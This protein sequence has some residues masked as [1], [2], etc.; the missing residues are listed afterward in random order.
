MSAATNASQAAATGS[1][2]DAGGGRYSLD[3]AVTMAT[4]TGLRGAGLQAF[5]RGSG[6]IEVDL[7]GVQRADSGAL[8]LMVDWLAWSRTAGRALR[9]TSVPAALLA[10]ARLSGVDELLLGSGANAANPTA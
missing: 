1:I 9:Y 10:L 2:R 8:A 3:G 4:V 6:A 7:A 5:A